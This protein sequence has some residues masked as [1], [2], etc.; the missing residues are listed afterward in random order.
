MDPPPYALRP[1]TEARDFETASIRSAAPSYISE[2]PSYSSQVPTSPSSASS[3]TLRTG[4]PSPYDSPINFPRANSTPSLEAFRRPTWSRTQ[5]NPAARHY[6][7]VA[8]RRAVSLTMHE[9]ASVLVA[10]LNGE[11]GIAQMK[12]KMD[13]EERERNIRTNEDPYLVGEVAAEKNK[14]ERLRRENG[15]EVLEREDKRWDWLIAQM[16][17]WEERD[18]SWKKFRQEVEGGKRAKLAKRLGLGQAN[19]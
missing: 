15:W 4:L 8:H 14:L 6:H 13:E 11:D 10:A 1:T 12:K 7:S 18:K 2:A 3:S 17:D 19:K 9:Q 5:N 16:A